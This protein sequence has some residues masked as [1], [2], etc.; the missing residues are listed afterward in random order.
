[1][2]VS[3]G[4]AVMSWGGIGEGVLGWGLGEGT[5]VFERRVEALV[6]MIAKYQQILRADLLS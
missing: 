5:E 4:G 2:R 3:F 6:Y 1:M